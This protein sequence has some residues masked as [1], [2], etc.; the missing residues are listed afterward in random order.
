MMGS[1][2]SQ[3]L[4][5]DAVSVDNVA[6]TESNLTWTRAGASDQLPRSQVLFILESQNKKPGFVICCLGEDPE[7][8]DKPFHLSLLKA[9]SLPTEAAQQYVIRELPPYLQHGPS[10]QVH[11]IVSTK[12]GTGLAVRVWDHVLQPL[13]ELVA[14]HLGVQ[15]N[16]GHYQ[17][18]ITQSS[19]TIRDFSKN[20]WAS[21]A[22]GAQQ[23]VVLLSGDGG[24]VD[25]L[26]GSEQDPTHETRS[27]V[28]LLPLGTG[29]ALF[30][31]MHKPLYSG[32]GP[33]PLVHGLRTL[34]QGAPARLPVFRASFSPGSRIVTFT[35][36][37]NRPSQ[38][39]GEANLVK[40]ETSVSHLNG[41]I[42]ASYGFHASIVYESDTPEHRIHGDKR[43]G[44]VAAELL[45]ESH[46]YAAQVSIRR[47]G[48]SE[49]EAVPRDTHAYVLATLVSNLERTFTI[50]PASKPLQGHLRLVHFGPVGGERTMSVMM[51]A[52]DAGKHI[53]MEWDDGEKVGYDQVDEVRVVVQEDDER[54]RKVCI[55]GTIV[56]IPN[57]GQMSVR[58]LERGPLRILVDPQALAQ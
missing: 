14:S 44:M 25:L 46:P 30:H 1:S 49:F 40:E 15:E 35:D 24:V 16:D 36:K 21:A 48:S 32:I 22:N 47:P 28:A 50:S 41:A 8:R 39:D 52:Y 4:L 19:R 5:L 53:G 55:D 26:N 57:G 7:N 13:W 51:K 3:A 17:L 9:T 12:S 56:E 23:T 18:T 20:L 42:V 31:S 38:T 45:K 34:F 27:L 43:F 58:M 2:S 10:N 11:V 54:W 6:L 29:N 33:T 37:A